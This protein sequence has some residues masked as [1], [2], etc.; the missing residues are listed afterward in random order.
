MID[1]NDI[2]RIIER[3]TDT[4]VTVTDSD[5]ELFRQSFRH[6]QADGNNNYE[7]LEYLG[8]SVFSS[9]IARYLYDRYETQKEG[10]LTKM[11]TKL[12][13]GVMLAKLCVSTGLD[14]YIQANDKMREEKSVK[15][16]VF[17]AFIGAMSYIFGYDLTFKWCISVIENHVDFA[18]LVQT[19]ENPKDLLKRYCQR[20]FGYILNTVIAAD[21]SVQLQTPDGTV[22]A[23]HPPHQFGA[24]Y[25]E[26]EATKTA[27]KIFNIV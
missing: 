5:L 7:R 10:F 27:L 18:Y 24:R 16:D 9:V 2:Q 25:S 6:R 21:S 12:I 14:K 17:E 8:D 15:E 20:K 1:S 13:N 3:Y 22:V 23:S 26:L 19:Q 4:E 11:R